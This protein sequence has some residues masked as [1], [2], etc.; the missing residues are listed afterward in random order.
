MCVVSSKMEVLSE[1]LGVPGGRYTTPYII[2][3]CDHMYSFSGVTLSLAPL[4]RYRGWCNDPGTPNSSLNNAIFELTTHTIPILSPFPICSPF[5]S[6]GFL[7]TCTKY[8][9]T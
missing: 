5:Q 3:R 4:R 1:E 2:A 8:Y 9:R 6:V 7:F